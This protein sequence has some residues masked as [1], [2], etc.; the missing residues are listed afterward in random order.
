[1]TG[2]QTCALP[3]SF[4]GSL[5]TDEPFIA[6]QVADGNEDKYAALIL[7]GVVNGQGEIWHCPSLEL[8]TYFKDKVRKVQSVWSEENNTEET[9]ALQSCVDALLSAENTKNC[10][11]QMQFLRAGGMWV[12]HDFQF[13]MTYYVNGYLIRTPYA[14]YREALIKYAFDAANEKPALPRSFGL[15]FYPD[16][17][18]GR[19]PVKNFVHRNSKADVLASF[20][21]L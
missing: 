9:A 14:F 11:Y 21:D 6:Q 8:N 20:R 15:H 5:T 1:M 3:I 13:R 7:S 2:V 16:P 12:P 10:F 4:V 18:D 17:V 19:P